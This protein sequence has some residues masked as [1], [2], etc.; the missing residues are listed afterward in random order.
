MRKLVLGVVLM[1]LFSL[2]PFSHEALAL[3][4]FRLVN[5]YLGASALQSQ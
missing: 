4:P 3:A 2:D 5:A 1:E